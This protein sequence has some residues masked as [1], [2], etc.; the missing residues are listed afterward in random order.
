[1]N[2]QVVSTLSKYGETYLLP[3]VNPLEQQAR[4]LVKTYN[5]TLLSEYDAALKT[6]VFIRRCT[7]LR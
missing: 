6:G 3:Y 5:P 2:S 1:M 4:S 7:S